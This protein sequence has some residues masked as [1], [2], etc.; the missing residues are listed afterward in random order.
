MKPGRTYEI[1]G[2]RFNGITQGA[3]FGDDEQMATNFPLVRI[4]NL[5]THHVSYARTHDHSSMAVAYDGEVTTHVDVSKHQ[6]CG[7]SLLEIVANGVAS[8]PVFVVV[9]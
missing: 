9:K 3:A 5:A 1:A 8:E 6:E 2:I 7:P 4:T